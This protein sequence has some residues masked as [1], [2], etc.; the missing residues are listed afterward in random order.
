[1]LDLQ[2]R[3]VCPTLKE[4]EEY[5]RNPVFHSFCAAVKETYKIEEKIEFS[6]CSLAAGW[7]VKFKKAGRALCTIYPDVS[8]FTVLV[9][10]GKKEKPAVEAMLSQCSGEVQEIYHQTPEGNGQRWLMI[11]VEDKDSVYEDVL[12]L[13]AIRRGEKQGKSV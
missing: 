10:I 7:N 3:T 8:C 12:R 6:S 9:V 11:P 4:V 5:V 2:D 1:M 13:L